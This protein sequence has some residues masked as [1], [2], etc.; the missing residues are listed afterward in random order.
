MLARRNILSV[1]GTSKMATRFIG[2]TKVGGIIPSK[3]KCVVL[4]ETTKFTLILRL[5]IAV[6][7]SKDFLRPSN[8]GWITCSSSADFRP[9]SAGMSIGKFQP[10]TDMSR[11]LEQLKE[12][13]RVAN[14]RLQSSYCQILKP[15]DYR[16]SVL[17][18]QIE[19]NS[20]RGYDYLY[21]RLDRDGVLTSDRF[22]IN[23]MIWKL[24]DL[25]L[26]VGLDIDALSDTE[27]LVGR[28]ARLS[29]EAH[30]DKTFYKYLTPV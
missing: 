3:I 24:R 11:T 30:D 2:I 8:L 22:P 26:A 28:S 12:K 1:V 18:A 4:M 27:D 20:K 21:V 10:V 25:L 29:A 23:E 15:G 6:M 9:Y 14:D 16:F 17:S 5:C 13:L 7:E 19:H